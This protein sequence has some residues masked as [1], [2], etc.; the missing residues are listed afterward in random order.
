MPK[1][2]DAIQE[3]DNPHVTRA[4]RLEKL[5]ALNPDF[6]KVRSLAMVNVVERFGGL[7][8][9]KNPK[10]HQL[11]AAQWFKSHYEQ[12]YG[13]GLG[14]VDPSLMPVETSL[15]YDK[16][17]AELKRMA[18]QQRIEEAITFLG[19]EAADLLIAHLVLCVSVRDMAGAGG[20]K[21]V[22]FYRRIFDA[23]DRLAHHL[24]YVA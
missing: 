4:Q 14:A 1:R 23:L 19:K 17:L 22:K 13:S 5:D 15:K 20:S 9:A 7:A 3:I 8:Y 24:G 16:A 12:R 2:M 10:P 21:H 6:S 11:A 18:R